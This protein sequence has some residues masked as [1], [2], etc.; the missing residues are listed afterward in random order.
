MITEIKRIVFK[1][2]ICKMFNIKGI[3]YLKLRGSIYFLEDY[4]FDSIN[5]LRKSTNYEN[6]TPKEFYNIIHSDF[7]KKIEKGVI[8]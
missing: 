5:F 6:K 2:K 1:P 4:K 3:C 8:N 7:L